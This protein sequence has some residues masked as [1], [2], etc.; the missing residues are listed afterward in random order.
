MSLTIVVFSSVLAVLAQ[1]DRPEL[2][3]RP[4]RDKSALGSI[5]GRVLLPD[6]RQFNANIK[7]TL[8]TIRGTVIVVF[9]DSQG[10]F[11][12]SELVPGNYQI[13]VD[14]TDRSRF[15]TSSE[16][17]QVFRGAPSVVTLTVKARAG[18]NA[19]TKNSTVSVTELSRDVPSKAKKEFEKA[20]VAANKGL[21]EEAIAHLKSAVAIYPQFAMA[22]NDLGVQLLAAGRLDEARDAL[23]RAVGLDRNAFNPTL[24]LGIVLVHLHRF[25]EAVEVLSRAIT[26]QPNSAAARLYSGMALRALG[27]LESAEKNFKS[28]YQ[29]GGAEYA[30]ALFYLGEIYLDRGNRNSAL[31]SLQR[32]LAEVPNAANGNQVRKMIAALR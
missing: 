7:I 1:T 2:A 11:E 6:G 27:N 4:E 8:Q 13:E 24:N 23:E 16:D 5:R 29:V 20:S 26:T 31:D 17:V 10:Q 14:P 9:T 15:D 32:Y 12:F 30:V 28:A 19:R 22:Y 25:A 21:T 18:S 3:N